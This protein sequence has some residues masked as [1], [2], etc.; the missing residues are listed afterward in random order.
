MKLTNYLEIGGEKYY[1]NL[2]ALDASIVLK[3]KD[4]E[5][6]IETTYSTSL[7]EA[8]EE[9]CAKAIP[10]ARNLCGQTNLAQAIDLMAA[11]SAVVTNDSGLM[12]IAAALGK[13]MVAVFGSSS[14]AFTPPLSNQARIASLSLACS[15]C[16]KREC[17]LG[18]LDCLEKLLPE[19]VIARLSTF[20]NLI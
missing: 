9:I 3:V 20:K 12:H 11:S 10:G 8:G 15:P 2:E 19:N 7:D 17:P 16:F 6:I 13:P 18:H 4:D 14:P 5:P 1:I